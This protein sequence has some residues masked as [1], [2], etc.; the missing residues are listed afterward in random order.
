MDAYSEKDWS[1]DGNDVKCKIYSG[2]SGVF[3]IIKHKKADL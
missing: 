1:I 3:I 2:Q